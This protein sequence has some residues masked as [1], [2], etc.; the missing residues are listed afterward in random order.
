MRISA[1]LL[2]TLIACGQGAP[3]AIELKR[4]V[5]IRSSGDTLDPGSDPMERSATGYFAVRRQLPPTDAIAIFDSGGALVRPVG[6]RGAGPGEFDSRVEGFGFGP[7]D[8]LWVIDGGRRIHVF[9]PPPAATFVRTLSRPDHLHAVSTFGLVGGAGLTRAGIVPP[10]LLEWSASE[11]R[12]FSLPASPGAELYASTIFFRNATEL[13]LGREWNYQLE[14]LGS[15]GAVRQRITR[16]VD[17]FPPG[18]RMTG[19]PW[20]VKPAPM[21]ADL[22]DGGDGL[23]WV[24]VRRPHRAWEAY[25]AEL[26]DRSSAM[27]VA[28]QQL[29]A[30]DPGRLFESVLEVFD[31][32]TGKFL[33]TLDLTGH[34][35]GFSNAGFLTEVSE[36]ETGEVTLQQWTVRLLRPAD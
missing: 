21:V 4:G 25:N 30:I 36:T 22:F 1:A 13:W 11:P 20:V 12:Q 33:A 14:L 8:S 29:K 23:L 6:R 10:K 16:N 5:L 15:D 2:L 34:F 31:S 18:S 7:G 26:G 28:P 9:S 32:A 24:L 17:W 19:P 3:P 35:T 27:P